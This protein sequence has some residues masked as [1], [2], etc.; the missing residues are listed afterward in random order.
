MSW[1]SKWQWWF[2]VRRELFCG[3]VYGRLRIPTSVILRRLRVLMNKPRTLSR[4]Q[5]CVSSKR[6]HCEFGRQPSRGFRNLLAYK[7][8]DGGVRFQ[9]CTAPMLGELSPPGNVGLHGSKRWRKHSISRGGHG[10][11]GGRDSPMPKQASPIFSGPVPNKSKSTHKP[12]RALAGGR[13]DR[14]GS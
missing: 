2:E 14:G 12:A 5:S 11:E 13:T 10:T 1:R 7:E 4:S 6:Q 3:T 9:C 8:P